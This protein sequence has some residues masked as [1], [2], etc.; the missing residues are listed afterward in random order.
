MTLNESIGVIHADLGIG[1]NVASG[2]ALLANAGL[3]S[4]GYMLAGAGFIVTPEEP[5]H[6]EADAPIKPYRNAKDLTDR[7]REVRII[8]L[9]GFTD[10]E[11]RAHWPAT[12]QW[13]VERVESERDAS[14]DAGFRTNWWLFGRPRPNLREISSAAKRSTR[15]KSSSTIM[16][17]SHCSSS[18]TTNSTPPCSKPTTSARRGSRQAALAH[19][20][21]GTSRRHRPGFRRRTS[22]A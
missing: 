17:S 22:P 12:Y 20:P 6:L 21:P 8:D 19:H 5:S 16:D 9:F 14:R 15:K 11:L 4:N 10:A 1:A 2:Q 7:P 3:S 18:C 13:V